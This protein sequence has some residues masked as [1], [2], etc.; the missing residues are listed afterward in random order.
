MNKKYVVIALIIV[1]LVGMSSFG[2]CLTDKHENKPNCCPGNP[3]PISPPNQDC[4]WHCAAKKIVG[5]KTE[6][7]SIESLKINTPLF[8][9][10]I[11]AGVSSHPSYHL[12]YPTDFYLGRCI[13]YLN[14]HQ[15]YPEAVSNRAPPL[16]PF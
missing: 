1:F 10:H 6:N 9:R 16:A 3:V 12:S 7:F 4:L 8:L 13:S 5:T 2:L 15:I 14:I 11:A